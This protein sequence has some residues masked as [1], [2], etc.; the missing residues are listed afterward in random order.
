M[1]APKPRSF[2]WEAKASAAAGVRWAEMMWTSKGTPKDFKRPRQGRMVSRSESEPMM[3]ATFFIIVTL[4]YLSVWTKPKNKSGY[5][6]I[7]IP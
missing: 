3:T 6:A 4:P 5:P 1:I 2:A 7:R